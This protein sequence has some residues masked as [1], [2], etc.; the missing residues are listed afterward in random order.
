V[1]NYDVKLKSNTI[2][3]TIISVFF[4]YFRLLPL[5]V[6]TQPF[7]YLCFSFITAFVFRDDL[8]KLSSDRLFCFLLIFIL[9]VYLLPSMLLYG[10]ESFVDY[11]KYI[12]C[13]IS[14]LLIS[15]CLRFVNI[16]IFYFISLVIT[17]YV[18]LF[19]FGGETFK[20]IISFF[21]ERLYFG[22]KAAILS[23]E[24][25]YYAFFVMLILSFF[26]YLASKSSSLRLILF[27]KIIIFSTCLLTGSALVYLVLFL[28]LICH[29]FYLYKEHFI[30][31]LFIASPFF[32]L[33]LFFLFRD[34]SSRFSQIVQVVFLILEGDVDFFNLAFRTETSGSSRVLLNYIAIATPFSLD[35]FGV[36]LGG[37][38]YTWTTVANMLSIPI[39]EHEVLG[40]MGLFSAQTYFANLVA[41]IGVFSLLFIFLV[42]S[43]NRKIKP[44]DSVRVKSNFLFI[45]LS[46]T[47]CF[48]FQCQITN[49][50]PWILLGLLKNYNYDDRFVGVK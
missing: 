39:Q 36:G 15:K 48:L 8:C 3:L 37:F 38:K 13:P 9:S 21:M 22:S 11:L 32:L 4:I 24:P 17:V 34:E 40:G 30:K 49:P 28:Y 16:K 29:A 20:I 41:D 44:A 31:S 10:F 47:I 7:F 33:I 12:A 6:E 27:C 19:Y 5:S 43:N 35:F 50:V 46:L 23:P 18:F 2:S 1:N 45:K 26:D 25:S 42:C 14:Y